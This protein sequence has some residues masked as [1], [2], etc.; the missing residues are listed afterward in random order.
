ME[1]CAWEEIIG[2]AGIKEYKLFLSWMNKQIDSGDSLETQVTS[3]DK[4]VGERWFLHKNSNT[5][6]RLIPAEDFSF[7]GFFT[8]KNKDYNCLWPEISEKM[9]FSSYDDF[10]KFEQWINKQVYIG[11]AK[12]VTSDYLNY[13]FNVLS[14]NDKVYLALMK[15]GWVSS[16]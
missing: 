12:E 2:F 13:K 8:L 3:E 10:Y 16:H 11:N 4:N 7:S 6:W 9:G 5:V 14:E 1:D 15:N